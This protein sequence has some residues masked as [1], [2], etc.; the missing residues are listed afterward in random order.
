MVAILRMGWVTGRR[1]Y[2]GGEYG[3]EGKEDVGRML[4]R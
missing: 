4:V 2:G 3:Q 1:L